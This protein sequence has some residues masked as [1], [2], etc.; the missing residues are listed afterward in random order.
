MT[1]SG[2]HLY[3]I[4]RYVAYVY[5]DFCSKHNI[6]WVTSSEA[7]ISIINIALVMYIC[8]KK[9]QAVQIKLLMSYSKCYC[10]FA[11]SANDY[12]RV[13]Q[14]KSAAKLMMS[15]QRLSS[16]SIQTDAHCLSVWYW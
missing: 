14:T 3:R 11:I 7:D 12:W 9:H 5:F 6:G 10:I 13:D 16:D 4:Y 2:L 8:L 1:L 15:S